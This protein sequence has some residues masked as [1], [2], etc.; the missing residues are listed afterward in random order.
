MRLFHG[1]TIE[2]MLSILEN[3]FNPK[4]I[5]WTVSEPN[6][7]YFFTEEFFNNEYEISSDEDLLQYAIP[8]TMDQARITLAVQ[9]PKDYRGAVL[10]FESEYMNNGSDIEPDTSCDNMDSCA[11]S[12]QNPDMK[13]LV[14]VY[15]MKYEESSTRLFQLAIF[16]D[17]DFFIDVEM[18]PIEV[19]LVKSISKSDMNVLYELSDF[20]E[21]IE[22]QINTEFDS[23]K[24]AA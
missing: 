11:V 17:R 3:G 2:N 20:N 23:R 22:Y 9:N 15:I 1:T 4:E 10:V 7:T 24:V 18:S 6:K 16:K 14:S 21:I 19:A 13:G 8:Y 12:L 5:N